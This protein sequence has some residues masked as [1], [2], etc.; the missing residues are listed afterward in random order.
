MYGIT[1]IHFPNGTSV[2]IE[3]EAKLREIGRNELGTIGE[4][5][6]ESIVIIKKEVIHK[7]QCSPPQVVQL[8]ATDHLMVYLMRGG[9]LDHWLRHYSNAPS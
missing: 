7:A 4:I 8:I 5:I 3:F 1:Y 9:F 2:Y 6:P